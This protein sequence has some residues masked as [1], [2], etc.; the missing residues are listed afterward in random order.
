MTPGSA[1]VGP[2]TPSEPSQPAS[3]A[4]L[5]IAVLVIAVNMR[6]TITGVGPLLSQIGGELGAGAALLGLLAAIPVISWAAVSPFAHGIA[7]RFGTFRV[8]LAALGLLTLGTIWRSLPGSSAGIWIGTAL[9]G[10]AIAVANVLLPAVIKRGFPARV[11]LV[12]AVYSAVLGGFG[13]LAS[14]L[15]VP[16]SRIETPTGLLGWRGALLAT[17]ALLP[18][19]ITLWLFAARRWRSDATIAGRDVSIRIW[20]DSLAWRIAAY[21]GAQSAGFY[22]L[23][24]WLASISA[25]TGRSDVTAGLDVMAYQVTG[26]VGSLA[27]PPLLHGPLR[28]VLPQSV[29][30]LGAIGVAGLLVAPGAVL[31]WALLTGLAA[32]ASLSLALTFVAERAREHHAAAALS[33]MS[34]SFG[35]LVAGTGPL[36]FGW[37]HDAT[38]GWTAPLALLLA[39]MVAQGIIGGS[40]PR[41]GFVLDRH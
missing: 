4:L 6:A 34:Q 25:S 37:L 8:V 3:L 1:T 32:G 13:A 40:V 36:V 39:F 24:T 41:Q 35:Y 21:M 14:G 27:V 18:V 22:I 30:A 12:M 23:V 28:R 33:G 26:I 19:A 9:I 7:H 38:D 31:A 16:V 17:G 20:R 11:P 15:V 29:A 2:P 10:V 5:F